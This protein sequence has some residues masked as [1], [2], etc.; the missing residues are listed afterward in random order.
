MSY[1]YCKR[2]RLLPDLRYCPGGNMEGLGK[3][4]KDLSQNSRCPVEFGTVHRRDVWCF[5]E[6]EYNNIGPEWLIGSC[7]LIT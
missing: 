7:S 2:K 1:K 4:T 6:T 3:T 5:L